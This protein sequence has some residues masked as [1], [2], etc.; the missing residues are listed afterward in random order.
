M[1]GLQFVLL[2]ACKQDADGLLSGQSASWTWLKYPGGISCKPQQGNPIHRTLQTY[3]TYWQKPLACCLQQVCTCWNRIH[4]Q[5][6]SKTLEPKKL[7]N[8]PSITPPLH[9]LH[10]LHSVAGVAWAGGVPDISSR[11]KGLDLWNDGDLWSKM[12]FSQNWPLIS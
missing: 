9:S 3:F 10:S 2:P 4:W 8:I 6:A 12:Q 1:F 11:I 7:W 5:P